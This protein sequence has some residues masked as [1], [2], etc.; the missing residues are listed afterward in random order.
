MRYAL[1]D[2]G[3]TVVSTLALLRVLLLH[4]TDDGAAGEGFFLNALAL[5]FGVPF[6]VAVALA[7]MNASH[8]QQRIR[9]A[10]Q[11][12]A[13]VLGFVWC[14]F[15]VQDYFGGAKL[16]GGSTSSS[17]LY[18]YSVVWLLL[19]ISYQAVGLWREQHIIHVGSLVL[20]L[21]T[22]GKVFFVDAAELEG[23]FRVLSFLGLGLALIAI[24]FFYNKVV[25][26]RSIRGGSGSELG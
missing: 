23:L 6:L 3:V 10:Y 17:E 8:S 1:A 14:T 9:H 12:G 19:A 16:W 11:I 7:W 4:L 2:R 18:T 21:L 25:F 24:G 5:Q 13:M 15:L 26:V 22:V 20:L